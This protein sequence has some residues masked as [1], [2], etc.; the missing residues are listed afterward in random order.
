MITFLKK[1]ASILPWLCLLGYGIIISVHYSQF[2]NKH[3]IFLKPKYDYAIEDILGFGFWVTWG[4]ITI[5][6]F[7]I[8]L[9][10]YLVDTKNIRMLTIAMAIFLIMSILDYYLYRVLSSQVLS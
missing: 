6:I 4:V 1:T 3:L 10:S 2:L 7:S 8:N 5:I 9:A